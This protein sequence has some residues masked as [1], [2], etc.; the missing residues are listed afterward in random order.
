MPAKRRVRPSKSTLQGTPPTVAK[1][2]R[3]LAAPNLVA[4]API[5]AAGSASDIPAPSP[6]ALPGA[7]S[8]RALAPASVRTIAQ[9]ILI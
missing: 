5:A 2:P 8:S 7:V 4:G 1:R 3:L 9:A 6:R